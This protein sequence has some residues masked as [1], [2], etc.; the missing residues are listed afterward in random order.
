M[1]VYVTTKV[2]FP[3]SEV[4]VSDCSEFDLC[5]LTRMTLDK[6]CIDSL[7]FNLVSSWFSTFGWTKTLAVGQKM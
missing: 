7:V 2:L 1:T 3:T 6:L 5:G 4:D